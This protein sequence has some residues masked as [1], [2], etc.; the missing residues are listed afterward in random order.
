MTANPSVSVVVINFNSGQY[1]FKC[2]EHVRAQTY[3]GIE[4]MVVDNASTDGSSERL[5]AMAGRGEI[6]YYRS[7]TN[8]GAS[9]ANN[10]GIL[11]TTGELVLILNA[12]AFLNP[13]YVERCVAAFAAHP[14]AGSV[15]GKL[16]STHDATIIDSAGVSLFREGIA[17]DRGMREKD[18]GQYD[19]AEFVAGACCAA[20]FYRRIMLEALREGDEFYDED[21]FAFYEDVDL[22]VR[23]L[24]L[25]WKTWY[26]PDAVAQHVRGACLAKSSRFGE[27]LA[28]RNMQF[29][30][31]KT[32]ENGDRI[33]AFLRQI[34]YLIW[35]FTVTGT[36]GR[37]DGD[38]VA[39]ELARLRVR[40]LDKR[41]S[42]AA[43]SDYARLQPYCRKSY[44]VHT[45]ARRVERLVAP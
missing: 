21:F 32:F 3:P 11:G 2:L 20:A 43:A 42:L 25:G 1:I 24:L 35:R 23:A 6:R 33:G 37:L 30:Y 41:R 31:I 16:V 27:F 44:I 22:S 36:P 8:L 4:T 34:V 29:F 40:L 15:V 17:L 19:R 13:D 5:A 12:D 38:R 26:T 14:E 39:S 9:K 45:I 7:E 28:W 18:V 10:H